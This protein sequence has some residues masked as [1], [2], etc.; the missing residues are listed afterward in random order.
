MFRGSFEGGH[1]VDGDRAYE[2]RLQSGS[3]DCFQSSKFRRD[4]R[5]LARS[6]VSISRNPRKKVYT[7]R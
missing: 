1:G 3:N 2:R 7:I 6:S 5:E 4:A